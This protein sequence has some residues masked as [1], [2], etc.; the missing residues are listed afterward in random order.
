MFKT[1][2][3]FLRLLTSHEKKI[4]LY[5]L[6]LM[7]LVALAETAGV[8]SVIP[9]MTAIT[10]DNSIENNQ[11][12]NF[13]YQLFGQ[14]DEQI[15]TILLASLF[16]L[17]LFL[18]LAIK[19]VSH[20][21]QLRYVK[22]RNHSLGT[23]FLEY[24]FNQP[25][26]WYLNQHTSR[27]TTIILTEINHVVSESLFPVMQLF[28]HGLV[29]VTL[30]SFLI[31]IDPILSLSAIAGLSICYGGLYTIFEKPLFRFGKK[32]YL[33]NLER[34]RII[35]ELFGGIKDIK[36]KGLE[37]TM[38]NRFLGPSYHTNN[39]EV[40]IGVVKMI[41]TFFMQGFLAAGAVAA[42]LYLHFLHGSIS[43]TLPKFSVFAYAG[44]RLIP[45]LQNIYR[46]VASIRAS[47]PALEALV[48]DYTEIRNNN[49]LINTAIKSEKIDVKPGITLR[50]I[51]FTYPDSERKALDSI[52]IFIPSFTRVGIV[53][54]TGSGKTTLVDILL[55]LLQPESGV[56]R[57]GDVSIDDKN[58]SDWQKTIGYVPQQIFLAD[59]TI[60]GNI[61]FGLPN[62]DIDYDAIV[63]AAKIADIHDFVMN[64][65]PQKYN[66]R[67][68]E[69]GVRLSGGQRQRIGIARALYY[70]PDLIIM[71]EA[72]SA[73]DNA[74]EAK[75]MESVDNLAGKKTIVMI[76]HRL[77][78]IQNCDNIYLLSRGKI[79]AK[80]TFEE[81]IVNSKDFR[82]LSKNKSS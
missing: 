66:T 13:L 20:W 73:L 50:D 12:I 6:L 1:I 45:A 39:E 65:L 19:T 34:Y 32:R 51:S 52:N 11:L 82:I 23:R 33:S 37:T 21:A 76:A 63:S 29:A 68:G 8:A 46:N 3:Y 25:Y 31:F 38:K 74:T 10:S 47:M 30:F 26:V 44:Y 71:D 81:L 58:R 62:S 28:T 55:G 27:L 70:N 61:A 36:V 64:E 9:F 18:T 53:G 2:L 56:I 43:D 41:P 69:R 16:I 48:N 40:K 79:K 49:Q 67:I 72:T 57:V 77:T 80:G 17:F 14:P 5:I 24:Y 59:E 22:M 75:V 54:T 78:T 60:A 4:A 35:Q 15:F 42:L 7:M